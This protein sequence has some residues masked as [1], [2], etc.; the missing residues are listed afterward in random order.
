M[1]LGAYEVLALV[2]AGGMGEVYRARD[3]RLDRTVAIKV[4]AASLTG[5]P[6]LR[7]RFDREARAI[8][9]LNHPHICTLYDV[10]HHD[11]SPGSGQ[12]AV[13]FL[14]LEYLEGETL[15]ERLGRSAGRPLPV[16]DALD[17]AT[18]IADALDQAHRSGIVHRDLK[19]ANV[20]LVGKGR[21][22]D[23]PIAKLLDFGLAK[24]AAP[25][26]AASGLSMLPTTPPNLTAQGT[27]LGTFQYMAP[28]QIEGLEADARTDIFAFGALLF[29]ML[30]GRAAFEGKT[31]ASLLGAIL[32]DEPPPVSRVRP[33]APATLDRIISTCLAKDPDDRYQSARDLLRDLKWVAS[34]SSDGAGARAAA[35]PARSTR[36]AWLVAALS[37]IAL[38]ATAVIALRR[39]REVTS[40]APTQFAI[41]PPENTSL[42]GPRAGGTGI[43]A[44]VA[45]SP[46]GRNVVFV[47]GTGSTYQIWL[48]P[49]AS[50]APRAIAGTEDGA[51]PFWSPDSRFIGFFAGGKL[52]KV[53]I[54]GGPPIVL[55]DAPLG[56]GGS[57]SRENVIL[58][59]TS[60]AARNGL[61]R[62]SSAGGTPAVVTTVDAANREDSHRWP[63]FL[64]DGR[65]FL[66]TASTGT[67]CPASKPATIKIGSLDPAD[68]AITLL[69]AESS[70]SY[71][72]GHLLFAR[73]GTLMAQPFDPDARQPKGDAFPLVEHVSWEGSRYVGASA[74]E[75]GT[76]VYGLGGWLGAQQL[77]WFDRAGRVL[78]TLGEA[79]PYINLALSPDERRVAVALRTGSPENVDIW[80]I[81]VARSVR[82]RLTFDPGTDGWPLWS[83]DGTRIAFQASRA[84]Q[85]ISLRQISSDGTGADAS[86][87]DGPGNFTITP[88]DWS[89]D[90][91][92]IAYAPR[93]AGQSDIWV[94]PLFGDRKPFP[95][96]QTP[97]RESSAAFSPDGRWIAYTSDED[98]RNNVYVQPFPGPGA[99]YPVSR[100]GGYQPI[101][102]AD[103]KE[104][105]YVAPDMSMTAV[106]ID[107][108]GQFHAGQ[109]QALFQFRSGAPALDGSQV[110]AVTKDGK[111]FLVNARPAEISAAP[112]TVVVNWPATI[113]K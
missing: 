45:V 76:L 87:L 42:G 100:N 41:V 84:G 91:R 7:E 16:P 14:V 9:S 25:V 106:P 63:H 80:I 53:Q 68:G 34:G 73:D 98:G 112:L 90:G 35:A 70:V 32:K 72:S 15:A 94:L 26:V 60:S 46:D 58:F 27:I 62:V 19:P 105:F 8:S 92:F 38:I 102:R 5:D 74:S 86:L 77:T 23:R 96:T 79:A 17:I 10:G 24:S 28:E 89:A 29:E 61:Q 13:D 95:L 31:R 50:L 99:K 78:G 88:S 64:P 48:R 33:V 56:R 71:A 55:C 104:L 101:W 47:A 85:A 22:S 110:Y 75:N 59:A 4:L 54:A 3:T 6:Q 12:A 30:T 82:S 21:S 52:K 2:G 18:Q 39:T 57:W 36:V 111:R 103:G 93:S 113:Q 109:P 20:F 67:C 51:F 108:A 66:Y 11:P 40:A 69:Q 49:V 107:S 43:A 44:Q 65:H 1:H 83:P 81:D 97:F 37:T